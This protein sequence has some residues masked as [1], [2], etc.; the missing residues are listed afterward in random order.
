MGMFT[1]ARPP[2]IEPTLSAA[3]ERRSGGDGWDS[4]S[5]VFGGNS[6]TSPR[7]VENLAAVVACINAISGSIAALPARCYRIQGDSRIE[8]PGHPVSRLIRSGPNPR[9]SWPDWAEFTVAQML[10]HGSSLSIVERDGRGAVTSLVP[11]PW[12]S[13][14]VQML[15]S[16]RL[17]FDVGMT[18]APYGGPVLPRRRLLDTE[19]FYLKD[20][21]DDGITGRSR[22]SRAPGVLQAALG[23]AEYS[24]A[25]WENAATP[26]GVLTLPPGTSPDG[27]RR[28]EAHFNERH[29]GPGNARRVLFADRDSVW[30]SLSANPGDAE[31]LDSRKFGVIEICRL[32]NTPPPIIQDY[33]NSTFT[34]SS[35]A[36]IWWATNT[37]APLIRKFE[38]EF[39]RSVFT[40]PAL[41][42][43][44]DLSGLVRGSYTE[45]WSSTIAAVAAGI[46]TVGEARLQEDYGP[47]AVT[48][49]APGV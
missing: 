43:S 30:T 40:D 39:S 3:P 22:L 24:A 27:R 33:S 21:S 44:I 29:I 42:L 15:P 49:S 47:M 5:A 9:Q 18:P 38:A 37:L 1:R 13:V 32:F 25:I 34:N 20:R 45:R 12:P 23:L 31:V 19:V 35:Q 36:S 48:E 10:L 46:I 2:R 11:V 6:S 26:S 16:G 28:A 14:A 41:E 8:A 4:L 7:T 17:V